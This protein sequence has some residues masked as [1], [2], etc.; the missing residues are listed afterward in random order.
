RTIVSFL[1]Y[2]PTLVRVVRYD[3]VHVFSASYWSYTLWSLPAM[4]CGRL[5]GKKVVLNYRSGEAEDH[6]ANW[7]SALPTLRL[8]HQIV[9]PTPY[10]VDVFARFGLTIRCISNILDIEQFHYRPRRKLR[11]VF[12]TN[13]ILEPLYN[14][15]CVLRAFQ[16]VQQRYPGAT[17]TIAHDGIC[18]P[19]LEALARELGLRSTSFAGRVPHSEAAELYDRADIYLTTPNLDC[20]PGSILECFASGLPVVATRAGGIPYI[21]THEETGLLVDLDDHQAVAASAMRLL[22][23]E[24][25]VERLTENARRECARYHGDAVRG[26]WVALYH[27]LTGAERPAETA[28]SR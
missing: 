27:E 5:F 12:L 7:R 21:L 8:A 3:I 18:R 11:P 9:S 23:N 20:M 6:L 28:A 26:A 1:L 19:E 22:E 10:L 13:R 24:A 17:L 2:L 25:L 4:I 14:V 15:G 16:I